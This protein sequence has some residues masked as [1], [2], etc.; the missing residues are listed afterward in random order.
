M[1]HSLV[2][3]AEEHAALKESLEL[4]LVELR[5]ET[6]G[7][8]AQVMQHQLAMRLGRLEAILKRL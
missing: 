8:E 2:L 1:P 3:T 7:T 5:R 4:Y 6:A